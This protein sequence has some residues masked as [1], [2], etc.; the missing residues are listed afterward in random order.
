MKKYLFIALFTY[1]AINAKSQSSSKDPYL[2]KSLANESVK[3]VEAQTSGGGIE[4]SGGFTSDAR[5]EVYISSNNGRALDLSKEEIAKRLSDDYDM[6]ITVSN[7]KVKAIAK[8]KDRFMNWKHALN[9]SFKIFVPQNVSTNLS[10]SGGGISLKN[11][12]GTQDF[13]TS[14]G[15]LDIV[16]V[17]GRIFGNT[18]GGGITVSDSKDDI[19]LHT[20]GGGIEATNCTGKIKLNTSGG[21]LTLRDLNGDITANTSGGSVEGS[22]VKG[23]LEA[24]TSGGNVSLRNMSCSLTASTS[25]GNIDV[26]ITDPGKYVKL[27][28]SGGN[29]DLQLPKD[30][31]FDLRLYGDKI[32]TDAM[33]NFEGSTEE[34]SVNGKLNG[35]GIPINVDAGSG[36]VYLALK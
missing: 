32:K 15:G 30:K 25:G 4:V 20:S 26:E 31:G 23:E 3:D 16:K 10:T 2:V 35:G 8:T 27:N 14:G 9:I 13:R 21:S 17:S 19:D 18:S 29:I 12:S 24:H 5:V 6:S 34:R 22:T 7:G 36:R 28:N 11:L 33:K 1:I